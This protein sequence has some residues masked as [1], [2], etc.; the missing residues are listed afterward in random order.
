MEVGGWRL[1]V[2]GWRVRRE[3]REELSI[4]GKE[5]I[6]EHIEVSKEK[7]AKLLHLVAFSRRPTGRKLSLPEV[8]VGFLAPVLTCFACMFV[9]LLTAL[10]ACLLACGAACSHAT[11]IRDTPQITL[12]YSYPTPTLF[13]PTPY[14]T[15]PYPT[16]TQ[17][18]HP[19]LLI[20]YLYSTLRP[21]L[22]LF[23]PSRCAAQCRLPSH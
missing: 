19:L 2:G 16:L 10:F 1:E 8:V 15:L 20:N 22:H 11:Y 6:T 5:N 7:V 4:K 13:Y 23:F 18:Y 12:P 3:T 17:H 9:R 14:P 21:H